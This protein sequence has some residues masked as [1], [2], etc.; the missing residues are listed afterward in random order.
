MVTDFPTAVLDSSFTTVMAWV[1]YRALKTGTLQVIRGRKSSR[2]TR[3]D[4]PIVYW[5]FVL[6]NGLVLVRFAAIAARAWGFAAPI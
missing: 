1:L 6:V 2:A 5:T 3:A 4:A